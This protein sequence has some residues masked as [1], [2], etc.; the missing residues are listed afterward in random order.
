MNQE[1]TNIGTRNVRLNWPLSHKQIVPWVQNVAIA[2]LASTI[3]VYFFGSEL[4]KQTTIFWFLEW[5]FFSPFILNDVIFLF[6]FLSLYLWFEYF[7]KQ[8]KR[9]YLIFPRFKFDKKKQQQ[10]F[11]EREL[12][13]T[14]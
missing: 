6:F 11:E 7:E 13:E 5:L 14:G 2:I 10:Q 4:V 9:I 12:K 8:S 1:V 3:Y